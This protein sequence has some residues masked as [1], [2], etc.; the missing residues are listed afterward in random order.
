MH[1]ADSVKKI[2]LQL[3][4]Q[5]QDHNEGLATYFRE[6]LR[7]ILSANK[8]ERSNYYSYDTFKTDSTEWANNPVYGWCNKN[9]KPDGTPYNLYR[10][11]LKIYSTINSKM[12][13]YGEDALKEHLS[14]NL[15]P[16]FDKEQKSK[17]YPV[18]ARD[19]PKDQVEAILNQA[20]RQ[21]PRFGS[22]TQEGLSDA[23]IRKNFNTKTSM[24]AQPNPT[25]FDERL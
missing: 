5:V 3:H 15:Q 25:L 24:K 20:V 23:E 1:V 22:L 11:G 9:V 17:G 19:V 8:P 2:P 12:Q 21:S 7:L 4:Y 18:Y 6:T 14:Q 16:A 13:Q 10:D